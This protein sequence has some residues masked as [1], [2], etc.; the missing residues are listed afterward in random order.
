MATFEAE[1]A[2]VDVKEGQ[3]RLWNVPRILHMTL[4]LAD[5]NSTKDLVKQ[6][7][8]D[9]VRKALFRLNNK[10]VTT[11]WDI[12]E[13]WLKRRWIGREQLRSNTP[14]DNTPDSTSISG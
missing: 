10:P 8:K 7:I 9:C 3:I 11:D 13:I 14:P 6:L 2:H 4:R 5:P 12:R 1:Q